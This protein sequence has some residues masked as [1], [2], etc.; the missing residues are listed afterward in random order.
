M[1]LERVPWA[2]STRWVSRPENIGNAYAQGVEFDAKFRVDEWLDGA[3][4]VTVRSNLSVTSPASAAYLDPATELT[5]SP[6]PVPPWVA[7]TDERVGLS[8]WVETSAGFRRTRCSRPPCRVRRSSSPG[9]W[10][11]TTCGPSAPKPR[12]ASAS[13]TSCR[14]TAHHFHDHREWTD[15][16][17]GRQ[18]SY[19]P[20]RWRSP[21]ME[22]VGHW[23]WLPGVKP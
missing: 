17:C 22:A 20:L 7:T 11:R 4:H 3:R 13:A 8:S 19:L 15:P 5:S 9:C 10:T 6:A 23:P 1:S 12:C 21:G 14:A 18:W 16:D 2:T